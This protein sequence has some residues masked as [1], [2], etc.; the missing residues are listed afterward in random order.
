MFLIV[1]LAVQGAFY[2]HARTI[3]LAAAQEGARTAA[4]LNATT[5]TG[6]DAATGFLT[7]TGG[8]DVM[9]GVHV[10]AARGPTTARVVV[11]GKSASLVPGWHPTVT[12]AAEAPVE[13]LTG[14]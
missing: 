3:A 9:T 4:E 12:V 13:R 2:F 6:I 1:L 14:P 10:D 7:D 5:R 11:T 8:P